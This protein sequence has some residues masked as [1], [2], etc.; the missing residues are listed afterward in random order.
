MPNIIICNPCHRCLPASPP[1]LVNQSSLQHPASTVQNFRCDSFVLLSI[2]CSNWSVFYRFCG[3]SLFFIYCYHLYILQ[4]G[5]APS[6]HLHGGGHSR[7]VEDAEP[8]VHGDVSI[9]IFVCLKKILPQLDIFFIISF[10][11]T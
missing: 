8:L 9:A 7:A 10:T 6:L 2:L 4:T 5:Q 1:V 11:G 3:Q